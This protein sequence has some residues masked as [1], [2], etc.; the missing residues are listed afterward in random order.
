M[1]N[2][3]GTLFSQ[4]VENTI[5]VRATEDATDVWTLAGV[6]ELGTALG[7]WVVAELLPLMSASLT[8]NE[9]LLTDLTTPTAISYTQVVGIAGSVGGA[10]APGNVTF[11]TTFRTTGRGRSSRG[12][13]Y[14]MGIPELHVT[15]NT[16]S[17]AYQED[18]RDAYAD[19]NS[20]I[21][22]VP[23]VPV[24]CIVSRY[25]EGEPR[26]TALVQNVA[27][28]VHTDNLIDSQR[29]RLTGRGL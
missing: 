9:V 11:T 28:V 15:G 3:R 23:R 8:V 24:H 26:T 2:I 10:C 18:I 20:Y 6:A 4:R 1:A 12:R 22:D 13:N 21:A 29:R 16:V 7:A 27:A 14:W 5:Y 19:L 25:S 17:S